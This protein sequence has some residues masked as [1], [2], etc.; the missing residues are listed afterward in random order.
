MIM[1]EYAQHT[2]TKRNPYFSL[3]FHCKRRWKYTHILSFFLNLTPKKH[4]PGHL[5]QIGKNKH[6]SKWFFFFFSKIKVMA[7]EWGCKSVILG[8]WVWGLVMVLVCE[9]LRGWVWKFIP[10]YYILS[11]GKLREVKGMTTKKKK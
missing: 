7:L 10:L 4:P 5:K 2:H 3:L 1:H 6:W 11:F 9:W 8:F